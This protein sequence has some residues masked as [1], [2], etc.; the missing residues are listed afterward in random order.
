MKFQVN[1]VW[2]E[3]Q[4]YTLSFWFTLMM[5]IYWAENRHTLQK[6]T[7]ALVLASRETGLEVNADKTNYKVM[8]R[9]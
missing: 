2:P 3:I 6:N 7:E 8:F 4:W 9:D 5:L 1:Q